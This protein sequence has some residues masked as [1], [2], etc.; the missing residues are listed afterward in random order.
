MQGILFSLIAGLFI[1]IQGVFNARLGETIGVW[2]TTV[3]VHIVGLL[4]SGT[5]FLFARDGHVKQ[6]KEVKPMYLLGGAFGV[7]I[8]F[9]ELM[10]IS[11][12]GA[13][14]AVSLLLVSQLMFAFLIDSK[15]LFGVPKI[16]FSLNRVAGIA[17]MILGI[18]IFK[19]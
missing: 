13:S 2:H 18:I 5:I 7:L 4:L 3:I 15:G 8:V 12:L 17:I 11:L 14:F 1:T 16:R 10:G 19:L 9:G 6:I